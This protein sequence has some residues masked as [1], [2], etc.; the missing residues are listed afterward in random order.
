MAACHI[1]AGFGDP[2]LRIRVLTAIRRYLPL[3]HA[4]STSSPFHE[5]HETGFKSYRLNLA[6]N[7]PRTTM[8]G[9]LWSRAEYDRLVAEYQRMQFIDDG[10]ELWWDIRP[11]QAFPTI[12]MRICDI[13]PRLEDALCIA[14]LYAS[15][16]RW[17]VRRDR[18][19]TLPPEPPTELIAE[20]RW[21]AQRYG[22]LAF[23]GD[24]AKGSGRVDIADH[25][26]ALIEE[27]A[28]DARAL[29]CEEETRRALTIVREGTGADR[30][31]DLYRLRRPGGRH[32][33]RGAA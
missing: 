20:D 16:I 11:S 33:R 8:P 14:A 5:G 24:R 30:Q 23:F 27:L 17:L 1:H 12:E 22:V 3:L 4:L 31:V 7:L 13:C 6:G 18:E 32:R 15:L 2:D 26:A 29:G 21:I 28:A 25:A 10:S 9:P 19:G